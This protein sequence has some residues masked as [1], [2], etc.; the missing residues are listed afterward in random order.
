MEE[1]AMS[2]KLLEGEIME[3][4]NG[5]TERLR[6][7][8]DRLTRERDALR[9]ENADLHRQVA[10]ST[11]PLHRLRKSL[12]PMY[13]ALQSV[14]GELQAIDPMPER[15]AESPVNDHILGVWEKWKAKLGGA[16]AKIITVLQKQGA[17]N[18]DQLMTLIGT[19]RRKTVHDAIHKLN[20]SSL[21]EKN[22]GRFSL[23]KL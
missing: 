2:Q 3:S 9:E 4:N 8:V 14:F 22:D 18:T 20:K 11:A 7:A 10:E 1:S 19:S 5:E 6:A 13:R 12:E 17:A 23:K 16:P 21:I 15:A